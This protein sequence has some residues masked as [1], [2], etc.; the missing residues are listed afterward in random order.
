MLGQAEELHLVPEDWGRLCHGLQ[1]SQRYTALAALE[2]LC[3]ATYGGLGAAACKQACA[4]GLKVA[5]T[6]R[7]LSLLRAP[8][9]RPSARA[10][11]TS[12]RGAPARTMQSIKNGDALALGLPALA[13]AAGTM[14]AIGGGGGST[15]A[16]SGAAF[17]MPC[18]WATALLLA[19][20]VAPSEHGHAYWLMYCLYGMYLAVLLARMEPDVAA[21]RDA[22]AGPSVFA[23]ACKRPLDARQGYPWWQLGNGSL[24]RA[25]PAP[26][27]VPRVGA[28]PGWPWGPLFMEAVLQCAASLTWFPGQG[29]VMYV[30]LAMDFEV[31]GGKALLA[32]GDHRLHGVTLPLRT[33]G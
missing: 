11:T 20:L 17:R 23:A 21:R 30:E 2:A 14:A 10:C 28:P 1:E 31:H 29:H 25:P 12:W 13:G 32:P 5:S 16:H 24:P 15:A 6:E 22:G 27:L 4:Y 18:L 33:M 8:R 7:E 3:L 26:P 9:G 19:A